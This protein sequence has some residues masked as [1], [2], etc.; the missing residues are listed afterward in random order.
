M[1]TMLVNAQRLV[2]AKG[3]VLP[4]KEAKPEEWDAVWNQ[5]G[6]PEK[7][8]GYRKVENL[9][10]GVRIDEAQAKRFSQVAH[11]IGLTDE[12]HARL[13]RFE[14]DRVAESA[15]ASEKAALVKAEQ[16]V[17]HL[18]KEWGSAFEQNLGL[19]REA[20]KR[21]GGEEI[22]ADPVLGNDPRLIAMLA[23]AGKAIANDAFIGNGRQSFRLSP[24]EA[25]AEIDR[26][27]LDKGFVEARTRPTHAGHEA[28]KARWTE[29]HKAAY[30]EERPA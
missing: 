19:A 16:A 9:P 22:M 5:L 14:A 25:R 18:R 24:A 8:D 30:P 20:A 11:E 28:A 1:A 2:G 27:M 10:N 6:R 3:V 26:L 7:P 21:F 15:Q 13:L 4:G 29:L 12:Q 17:Q 23:K